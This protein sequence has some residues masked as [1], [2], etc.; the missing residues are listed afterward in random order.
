MY[1]LVY[2]LVYLRVKLQS[3]N[4]HELVHIINS[5]KGFNSSDKENVCWNAA[6][7][8]LYIEGPAMILTVVIM[9]QHLLIPR[10]SRW[11]VR[12]GYRNPKV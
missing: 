2:T 10:S 6:P 8:H 11:S 12:F 1:T 7:I 3:R 9:V 4:Q 5:T